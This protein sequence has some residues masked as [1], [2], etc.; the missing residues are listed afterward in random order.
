MP[1]THKLS[2]LC[3]CFVL[4]LSSQYA[5][6]PVSAF[7]LLLCIWHADNEQIQACVAACVYAWDLQYLLNAAKLKPWRL[8]VDL[9]QKL[10]SVQLMYSAEVGVKR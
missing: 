7:L 10:H 5:V 3:V 8:D 2:L 9:W 6:H 4:L 1:S